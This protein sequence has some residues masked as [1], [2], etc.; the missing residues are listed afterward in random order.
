MSDCK[1]GAMDAFGG[2]DSG[3]V[4]RH[5]AHFSVTERFNTSS[6]VFVTVCSKDRKKIFCS[7]V[8]HELICESWKSAD[9][10]RVGR[11]V[12]MP[13]HIHFFCAAAT[14]EASLRKWVKYW[15]AFLERGPSRGNSRYG[16]SIFGIVSYG[17]VNIIL[18]NGIT[19]EI[20]PFARGWSKT[21]MIGGFRVQ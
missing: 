5:P 1:F 10:Y 4:R 7:D 19:F 11:Y 12:I 9:H 20:I 14:R 18:K 13:D 15:K 16:R 3:H 21:R 17:V 2:K 8:A 6:I